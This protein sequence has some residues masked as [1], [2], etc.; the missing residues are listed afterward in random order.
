LLKTARETI[1]SG[2]SGSS[3]Q[4]AARIRQE[5]AAQILE[6][7]AVAQAQALA[8]AQQAEAIAANA[9]AAANAANANADQ[10]PPADLDPIAKRLALLARINV[11]NISTEKNKRIAKGL[12]ICK[13]NLYLFL[14]KRYYNN[15]T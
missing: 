3:A 14:L 15:L 6:D 2:G 13:P 4:H 12:Q 8:A 7:Q 10:Q 9:I 1:N 11:Q 5:E